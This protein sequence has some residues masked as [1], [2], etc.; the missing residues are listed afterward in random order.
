[1]SQQKSVAPTRPVTIRFNIQLWSWL[2]SAAA[3]DGRSASNL[4][5]LIVR[6]EQQRRQ[7]GVR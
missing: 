2:Q 5:H 3:R 4:L 7:K 1:M 6:R